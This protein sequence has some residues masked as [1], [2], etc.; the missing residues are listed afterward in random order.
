MKLPA[1]VEQLLINTD[2]IDLLID[3]VH[4]NVDTPDELYNLQNELDYL[5]KYDENTLYNM[6][7]DI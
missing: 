4:G 3:I 2:D 7:L 6:W 5:S 1:K